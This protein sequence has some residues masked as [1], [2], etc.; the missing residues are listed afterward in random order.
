MPFPEHYRAELINALQ[1][2]NLGVV[3]DTIKIFREARAHRRCIFVCGDDSN[4]AI[5]SRLLCDLVR[6]SNANRTMKFR[7]F[8]LTGELRRANAAQDLVQDY[9]LVNE[10]RNVASPGD[11]VFGI[12]VSGN[13]K[14]LFHAIEYANEIR[15]RTIC[16]CGCAGGRLATISEKVILVPASHPGKVEDAHMIICRMIGHYF[17]DFDH[18]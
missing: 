5:A 6:S 16:L 17:V 13:S 18:D 11:V 2:I 8:A 10:L 1:S 15:C 4:A 9:P 7:I 14:S 3:E 12:N